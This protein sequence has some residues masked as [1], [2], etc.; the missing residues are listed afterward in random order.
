MSGGGLPLREDLL[1][2]R[3]YGAPELTVPVPLNVNENPYGPSPQVADEM[4]EVVRGLAGS[5]NRYPDREALALRGDLAAYLGHGLTTDRVWAGN[6][7]NE[8][9]LHVLQAFGGPGRAVLS[10]EPTYSMYPAYARSTGTRWLGVPRA[11]D[12]SIDLEEAVDVVRREAPS[13]TLLASPNNPTGTVLPLH[14][15]EAICNASHG[16]VVVDEAYAEFRRA[17]V[18]SALTLLD[19]FPRLAVARTMSKA[20]GLAGVRLGYLA[21]SPDLVDALRLVRLPYHLS[22]VTQ[23]L[24]RVALAHAKE[25]LAT[26]D[27]LRAE[28][29]R[30]VAW[31]RGQGFRAA[32]SDAN[33]VLFGMFGDSHSVWEGL[34]DQG[35]L[36][37]ETG[38]EGWLRVSIGTPDQMAAFRSALESVTSDSGMVTAVRR[39]EVAG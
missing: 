12:F 20:F 37:R 21:A 3:P 18:P 15:V 35:V 30:T 4:A 26:V 2:I 24:A 29:D 13:V 39:R 16:V 1:G 7:S 31:L 10:F 14:A 19:A 34:L 6:G 17:G 32:D 36:V 11:A 22:A 27:L 8:V 33:F 23:S 38:P 5:L 9:M 28:R 25:M